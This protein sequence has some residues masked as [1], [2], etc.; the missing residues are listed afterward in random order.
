MIFFLMIFKKCILL[1]QGNSEEMKE[2]G[3]QNSFDI[4]ATVSNRVLGQ[5]AGELLLEVGNSV[6]R[7]VTLGIICIQ[8]MVR[9]A[10]LFW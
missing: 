4:S 6:F 10:V 2:T 7:N 5:H 8:T 9:L 3:K 1:Y